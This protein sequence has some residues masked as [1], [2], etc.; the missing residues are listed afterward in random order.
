MDDYIHLLIM[1]TSYVLDVAIN[2][3]YVC[4][5]RLPHTYAGTPNNRSVWAVK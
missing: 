5:R 1:Y 4:A 2:F 3:A